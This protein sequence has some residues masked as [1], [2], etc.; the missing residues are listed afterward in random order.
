MKYF[1]YILLMKYMHPIYSKKYCISYIIY[2]FNKLHLICFCTS[3]GIKQN[4]FPLDIYKSC[5]Q[6]IIQNKKTNLAKRSLVS[7]FPKYNLS[8]YSYKLNYFNFHQILK[9]QMHTL[10]IQNVTNHVHNHIFKCMWFINHSNIFN[11]ENIIMCNHCA[12]LKP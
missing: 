7:Q 2:I 3:F 9:F 11:N 6:I 8:S 12:K 5:K 10:H 4:L 1:K